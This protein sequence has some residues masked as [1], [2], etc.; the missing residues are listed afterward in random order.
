MQQVEPKN[1]EREFYKILFHDEFSKY[2]NEDEIIKHWI[3]RTDWDNVGE[4]PSGRAQLIHEQTTQKK[5]TN[6]LNN[7]PTSARIITTS[8]I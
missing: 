4:D 7:K 3:P 8:I 2:F 6:N 1:R 5:E